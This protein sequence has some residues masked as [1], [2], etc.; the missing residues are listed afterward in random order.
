[1]QYRPLFLLLHRAVGLVI[2]QSKSPI[3]DKKCD[4]LTYN[5]CFIM[6]GWSDDQYANSFILCTMIRPCNLRESFFASPS[7]LGLPLKR[8]IGCFCHLVCL[9]WKPGLWSHRQNLWALP[10]YWHQSP[11]CY[12]CCSSRSVWRGTVMENNQNQLW[13]GAVLPPSQTL[14]F[15]WTI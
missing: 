2:D 13:K 9:W 14:D 1:M 4:S 12:C 15:G 5:S 7:L 11:P 3:M 8:S 10:P 6:I